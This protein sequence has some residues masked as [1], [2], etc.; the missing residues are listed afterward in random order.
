MTLPVAI[1][2]G[3]LAT[4]LGAVTRATPKSMLVLAGRPFIAWQ[5]EHLRAQGVE[6]VVLCV[7]HLGEVIEAYVGNGK[8]WG[9]TVQYSTDGDTLRGTGGAIRRALPLLGP[10]F[11]VL[12]G[13][14]FLPVELAPIERAYFASSMPVLMTVMLNQ[15]RWD[16]SNVEFAGQHIVVYDKFSP[17]P[18]MQHID[19][20]LAVLNA[21]AF[22]A[23]APDTTFDLALY[24]TL[25]A[26]SGTLAGHEVLDRFYEIGSLQGLNETEIYLESKGRP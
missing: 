4:R 21:T 7:G 23:F 17:T 25:A 5:L 10:E 2:A 19:Y 9:L 14:S 13:D 3:G 1:L 20:G 18:R 16:R 15:N 11:F 24:Y 6:Q 8:E 26:R 12:Y 22:E